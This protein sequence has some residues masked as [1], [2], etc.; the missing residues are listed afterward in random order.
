MLF[1]F[2]KKVK[3][4]NIRQY[5]YFQLKVKQIYGYFR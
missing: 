4:T 5:M 2:V 1:L 3:T